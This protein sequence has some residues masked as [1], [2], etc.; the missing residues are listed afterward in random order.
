MRGDQLIIE[1]SAAEHLNYNADSFVSWNY[2]MIPW[3]CM[4]SVILEA[5]HLCANASNT[6]TVCLW[7]SLSRLGVGN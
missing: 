3:Y 1:F 4:A 2:R 7:Q 5:V 6:R